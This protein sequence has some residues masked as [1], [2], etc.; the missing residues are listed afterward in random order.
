[1]HYNNY[2]NVQTLISLATKDFPEPGKP[3]SII[4]ILDGLFGRPGGHN[5]VSIVNNCRSSD[6]STFLI[7]DIL[8]GDGINISTVSMSGCEF[9]SFPSPSAIVIVSIVVDLISSV[10]FLAGF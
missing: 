6:F 4:T 7:A 2:Y 9:S 8:G 5:N 3:L 10:L 1:M